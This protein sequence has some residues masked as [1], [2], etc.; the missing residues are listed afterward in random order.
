M[1]SAAFITAALASVTSAAT[2]PARATAES[3][4][5]ISID[6]GSS[7]QNA[8]ISASNDAFWIGRGT[9]SSCP[10]SVGTSCPEGT[11]TALTV[12]QDGTIQMDVEVPGGQQ[13]Y[14]GPKGVL[15]YTIPHSA[16]TPE[17]SSV[18]GF[19]YTAGAS[20][21]V[22]SL[23]F[24]DVGFAACPVVDGTLTGKLYQIYATVEDGK[25]TTNCTG[26]SL[27]AV[28]YTGDVAAWE[29]N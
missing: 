1:R 6:S 26:I 25:Y 24:E 20:G 13:L 3:F 18:Q 22:G 28:S 17:G 8:A 4:T 5:L 9:S 7:I 21:S 14:V 27:G 2:I 23:I 19:K 10:D 29:Y 11:T 15:S 16:A 12:G